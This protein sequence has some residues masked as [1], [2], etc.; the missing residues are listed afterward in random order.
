MVHNKKYQ[1][2]LVTQ[3][4]EINKMHCTITMVSDNKEYTGSDG[5]S[6]ELWYNNDIWFQQPP[7]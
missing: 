5:G 6:E 1:V 4:W 3:T 7:N 2:Q